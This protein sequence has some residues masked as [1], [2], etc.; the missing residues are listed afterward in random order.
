MIYLST[1]TVVENKVMS[2][3]TKVGVSRG[4]SACQERS[5]R[6]RQRLIEVAIE[7][8]ADRG[9]EAASTRMIVKR[10]E[11]NLVSIPYYFGSKLGLYHA[12]AEY[13]GTNITQRFCGICE[14][15]RAGLEKPG[16]SHEEMLANFTDYIVAFA[17]VMLGSDTP[18]SWG[19]FIY[20]EQFEPTQA[21]E[22]LH[23]HFEPMLELGFA[24]VGRLTNRPAD[25][26]E[27]R[28]QFMAILAM[29]KFTRVDRASV[30]RNMGWKSLGEQESRIV[31]EMLRRDMQLLFSEPPR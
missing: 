21:F 18:R 4:R 27:T 7:V 29:L 10:A 16:V 22:I 2:S 24:Y 28:I 25:A 5:E 11:A 14:H 6:T 8:F 20:R 13:I 1:E 23:S 17:E 19:Q 31:T 26:P 9:F 15:A 3:P 12:A 30:L